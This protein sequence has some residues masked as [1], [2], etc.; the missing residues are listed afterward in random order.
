MSRADCQTAQ[1]RER[2]GDGKV[3]RI[4]GLLP[5]GLRAYILCL[6]TL[7]YPLYQWRSGEI[8]HRSL[9]ERNDPLESH[10]TALSSSLFHLSSF[11]G[12]T[13]HPPHS[14]PPPNDF[15]LQTLT[16]DLFLVLRS[17]FSSSKA[18][19]SLVLVGHSMGGSICSEFCLVNSLLS[20]NNPS[21]TTSS[22]SSLKD[23]SS[24]PKDFG[25]KISGLA[26]L[27]VVEGTAMS[28]LPGMKSI[29]L[30]R[31][32]GFE[33]IEDAIKWHL[34]TGEIR[35]EN[36]ARRSV[37]SL[38]RKRTSEDDDREGKEFG[39]T[40]NQEDGMGGLIEEEEEA[41]EMEEL[42][43]DSNSMPPPST[44]SI[45]QA[46]PITRTRIKRYPFLW[47]ADLLATAPFWSEWFMG[48]SNKFLQAKTARLLLLAG[49][50]RLDKELMIGQM[51]GEITFRFVISLN[52][53]ITF[54]LTLFGF[55]FFRSIGK[56]QLVVFQEVGHSL[57]EVSLVRRGI[58]E[59]QNF[60]WLLSN[61]DLFS[62]KSCLLTPLSL[63]RMLRIEQLVLWSTSGEET[64]VSSS[65]PLR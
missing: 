25:P 62:D 20:S 52:L 61:K 4:P 6:A 26:V 27:D 39:T 48:L 12:R 64:T 19:P 60:S 10:L 15:S 54:L 36:S 29:V 51:Q 59:E 65:F 35:N 14:N 44:S 56:Y 55:Y 28:A 8:Y 45:N 9:S 32:K 47:R 7:R 31:P 63:I 37:G 33:S 2:E 1:E 30:S 17:L 49:T 16:L 53:F 5:A 23:L 50:D 58:F 57:Q 43:E 46:S 38:I 24:F 18:I 22:T 13:F 34:E 21:S 41:E 11:S 3:I 40:S 42:N